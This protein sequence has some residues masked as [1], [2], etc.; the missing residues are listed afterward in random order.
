MAIAPE[1]AAADVAWSFKLA[2]SSDSPKLS[3][4]GAF[5]SKE[6]GADSPQDAASAS[7]PSPPDDAVVVVVVAPAPLARG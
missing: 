2:A 5:S 3:M 7:P 4:A 1:A 6:L